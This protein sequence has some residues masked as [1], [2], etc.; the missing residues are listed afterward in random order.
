[1]HLI[2]HFAGRV[3]DDVRVVDIFFCAVN[4]SVGW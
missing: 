3:M 2:A 4:D 1:M